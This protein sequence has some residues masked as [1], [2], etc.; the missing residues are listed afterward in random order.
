MKGFNPLFTALVVLTLSSCNAGKNKTNIELVTAMMDQ[1]AVK[2]Q[3]WDPNAKGN[4]AMRVPPANTVPRGFKPYAFVGQPEQA[5]LALKNPMSSDFSKET[6]EMGKAKYDIYC[7]LCHGGAGAGDG[8]IAGK[9]ILK[10][11]PLVTDKVK[12]FSDGRIFHIITDGQGVMG[13]YINQVQDEKA[14][15]AIVNYIRTLQKRAAAN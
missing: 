1:Q 2:F 8:Q 15:W 11:P 3:D 12:A 6:L 5:G 10:P 14:R 7:G 9:M 13:S 4:L